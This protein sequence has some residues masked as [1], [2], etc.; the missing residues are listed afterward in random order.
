MLAGWIYR[1]D[2]FYVDRETGQLLPKFL[3][4]L[5][6]T[7]GGDV[8]ARLLTSRA[9]G[10]P[11][12]PPCYHGDPYPGFYLGV[13]GGALTTKSWVD[14]RHLSDFDNA[15]ALI[16]MRKRVITEIAAVP[17][18]AL[19]VLLECVAGAN[20]TTRLQERAIRDELAGLR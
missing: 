2:S 13:L 3:V 18:N 16:L 1:H 15:D 9:N 5:A 4:A 14:L 8:V 17:V 20:D 19:P 11:E 6:H 12:K 10:R 7:P